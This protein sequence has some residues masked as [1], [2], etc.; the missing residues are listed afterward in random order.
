MI[1]CPVLLSVFCQKN[2]IS[3]FYQRN[4]RR[5]AGGSSLHINCAVW[6]A[7]K[8]IK[9]TYELGTARKRHVFLCL[10]LV[11]FHCKAD[12]LILGDIC[13]VAR[14][15]EQKVLA[16]LACKSYLMPSRNMG[17]FS[18]STYFRMPLSSHRTPAMKFLWSGKSLDPP[19]T[20]CINYLID[21]INIFI[22]FHPLFD[23]LVR[24]IMR[25]KDV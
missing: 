23:G 5:S 4:S 2:R 6:F 21:Y 17:A 16:Q 24:C 8:K 14:P 13:A 3:F 9:T 19:W 12:N 25:C 20:K 15:R 11:L 22:I 7:S 10:C 18:A 1:V